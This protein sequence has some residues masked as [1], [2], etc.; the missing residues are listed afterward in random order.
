MFA[1]LSRE[2]SHYFSRRLNI[3]KNTQDGFRGNSSTEALT[4]T[5]KADVTTRECFNNRDFL[6]PHCSGEKQV[7]KNDKTL[8]KICGAKEHWI[9]A[10]VLG[11]QSEVFK[12]M[13][14]RDWKESQNHELKIETGETENSEI[15][16]Q[17]IQCLETRKSQCINEENFQGLLS[18]AYTYEV[19][20]LVKDCEQFI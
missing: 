19:S 14:S 5:Q 16:N 1:N 7:L 8:I 15:I 9:S 10:C 2:S 3:P 20:W 11:S 17:F 4:V 13:F 18:L 12:R 6:S